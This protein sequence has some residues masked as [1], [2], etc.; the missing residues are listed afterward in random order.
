MNKNDLFVLYPG[1]VD[2][3]YPRRLGAGGPIVP[4]GGQLQYKSDHLGTL[5]VIG[6]AETR[7][8]FGSG[9]YAKYDA[10][11][12]GNLEQSLVY[13]N[14]NITWNKFSIQDPDERRWALS[15]NGSYH[16]SERMDS[17]FGIL[18][19]PYRLD[20]T[21]A[22]ADTLLDDGTYRRRSMRQVDALG[23][24]TR[25]E[26]KPSHTV[27]QV[28]LGYSYFGL[29]AGNKHQVDADVRAHLPGR[30]DGRGVVYLP[31]AAQ[32]TGALPL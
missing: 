30:L 13:R 29:A 6:G 4:R 5:E 24:T 21:Y 20:F 3:E 15:Y 10:P 16:N 23:F 14:E 11:V 25:T 1:Q 32:R 28:D 7:W 19:Q 2:T 31:A 22:D 27:D 17:H 8:D 9:V 12:V 18:Y 26:I